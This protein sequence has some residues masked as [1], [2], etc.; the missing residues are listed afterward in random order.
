MKTHS[1]LL[2]HSLDIHHITR[3]LVVCSLPDNSM[4]SLASDVSFFVFEVLNEFGSKENTPTS[5]FTQCKVLPRALD[6]SL[7]VNRIR[8]CL[9]ERQM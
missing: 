4:L 5:G 6:K 3:V 2:H 8:V 9:S 7:I 1:P